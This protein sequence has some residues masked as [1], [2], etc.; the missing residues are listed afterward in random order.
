MED[1]QP[2]PVYRRAW[3]GLLAVSTA[4]LVGA[5]A[6]DDDADREQLAR[7]E[8]RDER[9][10]AARAARQDERLEQL[11]RELKETK[12]QGGQTTP[13]AT[14]PPPT[15]SSTPAATGGA[16]SWPAGVTGWTVVLASAASRAEAQGVAA[17]ASSAGL[18]QVGILFSSNYSSLHSGYWVA[19]TG[20]LDRA[21]AGARQS[22]ARA[23]G[24]G[25]A[26][27]REVSP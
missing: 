1:V 18:Q 25:D 15:P 24:F 4:A 10:E 17:R 23:A 7:A 5:C 22:E 26:Y 20:V 2:M 16:D 19:Y 11:E 9:R 27:A 6:G 8:I 21:E 3:L 12:R 13:P 14:P